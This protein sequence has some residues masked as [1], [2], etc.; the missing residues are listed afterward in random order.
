MGPG[1]TT[2]GVQDLI[3]ALAAFGAYQAVPTLLA[4]VRPPVHLGVKTVEWIAQR[5]GA[6]IAPA[7]PRE[8]G[9][10]ER[11][12]AVAADGVILP[13]RGGGKEA[14]CGVIYEPEWNAARTPT[15]C[16]GLRKEYF[17]TLE[18]RDTLLAPL[19]A[20][21]DARRPQPGTVMAA[22][23]DGADG[24]WDGFA[25]YLSNR[26]E[27]LDFY[28]MSERLGVIAKA[29]FGSGAAGERAA[30]QWREAPEQELQ[31]WGPRKLLEALDAWEPATTAGQKV[32]EDQLRYF[33]NQR[34]RM[35]YPE[36]LRQGFPI[37]S[38]AVE[39]A[40][41]HVVSD[42][43]RGTGMRRKS[44]T[45]EPLLHARAALLTQP[46]LDLRTYAMTC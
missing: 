23:G 4:R 42:R 31:A 29:M 6:A 14:R 36:Y 5:W 41:K 8:Y 7:P 26:V 22:L 9:P 28:H 21:A 33:G 38:G 3:P 10:A 30:R 12:L 16:A 46:N 1:R 2:P 39:G 11:P 18:S 19:C 45:A 17:A 13:L 34:H 40:D 43:F 27:I 15:A 44:K 35:N 20:R 25:Q 32:R 37:G 24:I